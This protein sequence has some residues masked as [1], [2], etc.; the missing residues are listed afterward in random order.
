[1]SLA[2]V[3]ASTSITITQAIT[4]TTLSIIAPTSAE[5]EEIF[6]VY[7]QLTRDDTG[8][9]VPNMTISVNY[10]GIP[11]GAVQTD[12]QGV[13]TLPAAIPTAGTYTLQ[14]VFAGYETLAASNGTTNINTGEGA[15]ALIPLLLATGAIYLLTRK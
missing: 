1:M 14:A 5:E 7:G 3:S 8:E 4:S 10:N 6:T 15:T 2:P 13:Y 9:A 12:L 11:L